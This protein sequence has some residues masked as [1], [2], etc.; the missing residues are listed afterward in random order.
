VDDRPDY[1]ATRGSYWRAIVRRRKV[2]IIIAAA[3]AVVAVVAA[4]LVVAGRGSRS[5][6]EAGAERSFTP[7]GETVEATLSV[8]PG[9]DQ[10]PPPSSGPP[11]ASVP[12]PEVPGAA[13]V[14][15]APVV[16]YRAAGWL[17][18]SDENGVGGRQVVPSAAGAFA[19]SPDGATL[20]YVDA[21]SGELW[22]ADVADAG[23]VFIGPAEADLPSWSPDSSWVAYTAPGPKVTRVG[24]AGGTKTVLFPGSMP[25]VSS[26]GSL[27][28]GLSPAGEI[29][30]WQ[31]GAARRLRPAGVVTSVAC[32]AAGAY[33]GTIAASGG[34]AS[35]R[36]MTTAGDDRVLVATPAAP[37]A[38]TF[39]D[40]ML[41]P[42]GSWLAYAERSDDGYSRMYAVPSAGGAPSEL[43]IRRDCYPLRWTADGSALLF[44]EGNAFQG[45][46]TALMRVRPDGGSRRL[47]LSGVER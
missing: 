19:L 9:G 26:V 31:D 6:D 44:I 27:V 10:T 34:E 39:G 32:G 37:R 3:V 30:M 23:A 33:Y 16:A 35:V 28:E 15:R 5:A 14:T 25:S 12:D 43:C 18:V 24:R 46:P 29:V 36:L 11:N 13:G 2:G 7:A 22:L 4:G 45:D 8:E 17:C 1:E 42:D 20:A 40:L 47:L 41:S 38:V 21:A